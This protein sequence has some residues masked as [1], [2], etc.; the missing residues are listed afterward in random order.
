V[1]ERAAPHRT[2]A[3][4]RLVAAVLTRSWRSHV[5]T[6]TGLTPA[7]LE[8]IA[9]IL[10][11]TGAAALAW[12]Q[13]AVSPTLRATETAH[14]LHQAARILALEEV[15][16]ARAVERVC[17]ILNDA[18]IEPLLVKGWAVA[19]YYPDAYL[20]PYGDIDLCAPPYRFDDATKCLGNLCTGR[21]S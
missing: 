1:P 14:D 10:R 18:G 17:S 21:F 4:G 2:P 20:R 16:N 15:R 12:R 8:R 13:I 11:G 7:S 19:R 5:E 9:P 3:D 6:P